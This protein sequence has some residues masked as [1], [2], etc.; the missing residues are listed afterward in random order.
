MYVWQIVEVICFSKNIFVFKFNLQSSE[1]LPFFHSG[2]WNPFT[3]W[4]LSV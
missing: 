2:A 3:K 4:K 1:F